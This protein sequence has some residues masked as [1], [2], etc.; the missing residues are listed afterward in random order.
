MFAQKIALAGL[1]IA[2]TLPMSAEAQI[3]PYLK[4][5]DFL[6][7]CDT[8]RRECAQRRLFCDALMIGLIQ[9]YGWANAALTNGGQPMLYCQPEKLALNTN[10]AMDILRQQA[11][12]D[13]T[14][15]DQPVGLVVLM[16]LQRLFGCSN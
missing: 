16:S 4:A 12:K 5:R 11:E 3:D 14:I 10:Q 9:A 13:R 15:A 1:Y 2:C 8:H 6:S 7:Y